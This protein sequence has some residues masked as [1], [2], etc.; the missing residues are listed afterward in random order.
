VIQDDRA[1]R[2][3]CKAWRHQTSLTTG[4]VMEATKLSL[5]KWFVAI[6]LSR[7]AEIGLSDLAL[8]HNLGVIYPTAWRVQHELVTA[9]AEREERYRLHRAVQIDDVYLGG[10]RSGG[11]ADLGSEK[12][13]PFVAAVSLTE[14]EHPLRVKLTPIPGLVIRL[15]LIPNLFDHQERSNREIN[16]TN[17]LIRPRPH[18]ESKT[19]FNIR[20]VSGSSRFL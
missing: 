8:M 9:M 10:E 12:K 11:K 2:F 17:L 7:Q 16:G 3:Q 15:L 6:H 14:D 18:E 20:W 19:L 4:T 1:Q 5:T 13:I